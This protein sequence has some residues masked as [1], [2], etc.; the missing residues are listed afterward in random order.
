[1]APGGGNGTAVR[2]S[3]LGGTISSLSGTS[4]AAPQLAGL[5]ASAKSA[6]AAFG[7]ADASVWFQGNAAANV[8]MMFQGTIFGPGAVTYTWQRIRLPAL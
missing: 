3:V 2:S 1:M 4:M 5:Y 7:P 6:N 8:T